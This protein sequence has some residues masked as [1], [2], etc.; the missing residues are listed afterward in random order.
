MLLPQ[1]GPGARL[2]GVGTIREPDPA[3]WRPGDAARGIALAEARQQHQR[4]QRHHGDRDRDK[5]GREAAPTRPGM[6]ETLTLA[7]VS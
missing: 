5:R 2:T 3:R 4:R 1:T 7:L 6:A